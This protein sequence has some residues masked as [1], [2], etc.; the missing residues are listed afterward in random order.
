[1]ANAISAGGERATGGAADRA[2]DGLARLLD[3]LR[4]GDRLAS[5]RELAVDL[6]VSRPTL[7]RVIDDLSRD[8]RIESRR[9]SGTYVTGVRPMRVGLVVPTLRQR[10]IASIV[11]G[12]EQVLTET[13]HRVLLATD[14]N[15]PERQLTLI[16]Q[17]AADRADALLVYPDASMVG[18]EAFSQRLM[19]FHHQSESPGRIVLIDRIIQHLPLPA[20]MTDH[21]QGTYD[22]TH[23]LLK[24]G[25]RRVAMLAYG[26]E[27]GS[28]DRDRKRGFADAML[29]YGFDPSPV[30]LGEVGTVAYEP[31]CEAAVRGWLDDT[32]SSPLAFDALVC[33]HDTMALAACSVFRERGI[34]VPDDVAVVGGDDSS[35]SYGDYL[36]TPLT[37][38]R[39]PFVR[40]G[41]EAARLLL[42]LFEQPHDTT[43]HRIML[44]PELVIR[45]SS[46]AAR[47]IDPDAGAHP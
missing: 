2:R 9:G 11:D 14:R 16:D 43:I 27:G 26:P 44:R 38:I 18:S 22:A 6:G 24:N 30:L 4:P 39:Q 28:G 19:D 7:R 45:Q 21:A 46:G 20:V 33:H 40:V 35:G 36:S 1:M 31:R 25:R 23:L 29:E 34:R 47:E 5:E 13:G 12:V 3:E 42:R 32:A 37:T 17:L 15:E 8:G 41:Q 10:A